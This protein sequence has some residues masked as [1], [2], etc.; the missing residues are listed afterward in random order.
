M[1]FFFRRSDTD[2]VVAY[3]PSP[4]GATES[5]LELEEWEQIERSNPLLRSLDPDVE[6]LLVNRSRG[7]R[8]HFVVP[9]EDCYALV[10]LIRTNWRGLSGGSE[11]WERIEGFFEALAARAEPSAAG[12][13]ETR[14]QA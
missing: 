11:V 10:G 3:Y 2:R 1:A 13:E 8:H 6:A 7:A 9:I 4:A 14:W 5:L 12:R